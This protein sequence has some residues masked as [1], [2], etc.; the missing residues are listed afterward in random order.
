MGHRAQVGHEVGELLD[1]F[2]LPNPDPDPHLRDRTDESRWTAG[3]AACVP[4]SLFRRYVRA[5]ARQTRA[6]TK[7]H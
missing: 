4:R 3:H 7:L 6:I 1:L 2:E 5:A